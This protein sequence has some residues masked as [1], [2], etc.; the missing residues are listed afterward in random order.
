VGHALRV[1]YADDDNT[2]AAELSQLLSATGFAVTAMTPELQEPVSPDF[3][4]PNAVVICDRL[5]SQLR[6]LCAA[7]WPQ[8]KVFVLGEGEDRH[9]F[10]DRL[11][12]TLLEGH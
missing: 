10:R 6:D 8:A 7:L 4:T 2:R 11:K 5:E 1:V 9:Q 3:C 12:T